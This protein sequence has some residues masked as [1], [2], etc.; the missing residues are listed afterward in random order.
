MTNS[1]TAVAANIGEIEVTNWLKSIKLPQY[2]AAFLAAGFDD[3]EV[4][5]VLPSL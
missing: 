1:I 2:T 3:L 4:R 5:A